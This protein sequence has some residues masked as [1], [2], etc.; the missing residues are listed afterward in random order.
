MSGKF[1]SVKRII[2]PTITMVI[3]ASQL[4]GCAAA[5]QNELLQMINNGDAIEIEIA[6][7]D[8]EAQG[9]EAKLFWEQ[10]ALLET[11]PELRNA[12]DDTLGIT[13]AGEQKNGVLYVNADGEHEPNNTLRVALHNREFVKFLENE[14]T[15]N[16]L[17]EAAQKQYVD[18]EADETEKA[19]YM[20]INGYFNLLPDT[21][22]DYCNPD[23]TITR[24]EFMAMVYRAETPVQELT[25]DKEFATAVGRSDL[26]IYAQGVVED[27]YLDLESKSLNNMN[28]NGTISRAEAVY[29]LVNRY[30]AD[31]VTVVDIKEPSFSDAKDGGNIA[32]QQ[33]F[34]E[35][36]VEKEY[37][38]SYELVYALQNPENG[39][40]TDLYKSLIVASQ[41]GIITDNES[42]WDEGI[43]RAE[44]VE[45]LV[46][47]L[48]IET[49]I[50]EF[51][52]KQG[53]TEED[54]EVVDNYATAVA[55]AAE[56][57]FTVTET[58]LQMIATAD[59]YTYDGPNSDSY[60]KVATIQKDEI[61]NI[62]GNVDDSD[63]FKIEQEGGIQSYVDS[64]YLAEYVEPEATKEPETTVLET[65]AETQP[66]QKV[67]EAQP[68]PPSEPIPPVQQETPPTH[69]VGIN[70]N[71]G[72]PWQV[73]DVMGDGKTIY[74]G[75]LP[76]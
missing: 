24:A 18:I 74:G 1:M 58:S 5:N 66:E 49:G 9:E 30:L 70:P 48:K 33:L 42:R 71:T 47:A 41:K 67:E 45:I 12:W 34:I 72:K 36:G 25:A 51:N 10:L 35:N 55:E 11:N 8:N 28:Y 27:S 2:I 26:N 63:W 16:A 73:G 38:K 76:F 50:K 31:D 19:V 13:G 61:V 64:S 40:P 68:T 21:V 43:T 59:A 32:E 52:S 54:T 6:T 29:L 7:F 53:V 75:V 39:L 14:S 23:S 65:T 4:M 37:W 3:I 20:G 69:S 46:N 57:N 17:S 22:S 44:A 60:E 15:I 62:I 56:N